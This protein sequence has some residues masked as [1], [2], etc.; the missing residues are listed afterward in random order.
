MAQFIGKHLDFHMARLYHGTLQQHRGGAEG[1]LRFGARAGEGGVK[2][3][4][5][6]DQP[7]T[8]PAAT[9]RSL[10]HQRKAGLRG[11]RAQPGVVLQLAVVTRHAGNTGHLHELSGARLV[12]HR[13]NGICRRADPDQAG[14]HH[15]L[16]EVGVLGQETVSGVH[17]LRP[18]GLCGSD[19]SGD[20]QIR[21]AWRRRPDA[22][23]LVGLL[24]VWRF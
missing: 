1:G 24:H 7:H 2:T 5:R 12:A 6:F 18:A 20:V 9:G 19:D 17:R 23:G 11:L 21:F 16:R 13:A 14:V 15:G 8:A 4:S 3:I 22:H 10:D